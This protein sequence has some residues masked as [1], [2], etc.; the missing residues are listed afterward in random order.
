MLLLYI[1][2]R[3]AW[4]VLWDGVVHNK[5]VFLILTDIFIVCNQNKE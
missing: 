5:C 4:V 1:L 3:E 2:S